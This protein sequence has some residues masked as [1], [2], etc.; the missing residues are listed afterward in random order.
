MFAMLKGYK[1]RAKQEGENTRREGERLRGIDL[2]EWGYCKK[3]FTEKS[4]YKIMASVGSD[5]MNS[6]Y[7]KAMGIYKREVPLTPLSALKLTSLFGVIDGH[8][9]PPQ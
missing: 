6:V 1:N 7:G 9:V 2:V 8:N 5:F 4:S 3:G